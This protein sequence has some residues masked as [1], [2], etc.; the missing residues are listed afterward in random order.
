MAYN[1]LS[2]TIIGPDKIVAKQDGTFTQITGSISGSFID[3]NGNPVSFATIRA[4]SGSGDGTIGA[5]EDGTY[6]DGLFTDFHTGTLIGVPI[7]RFNELFKALVPPP[8]PNISRISSSQD[9][10]DAFLSFGASNDL[11]SDPTPYYT[12]ASGSGF[13][14]V[15]KGEIFETDTNGNH[16][17]LAIH[18]LDTNITGDINFH[19]AASVLG[20]STN[21]EANAF[22]NAETG[23]LKLYINSTSSAAHTLNLATASGSGN[24]GA[25]A[26]SSLNSSGSG[27]TNISTT[28][29]ATDANG[30]SFTMFNHRTAKF[31]VHSSSQRRGWNYAYVEHDIVGAQYVTNFIQWVN[32]D[33]AD[34][35][36]V[37]NNALANITLSGSRYIS[38]VQYNTSATADYQ[39]LINNFYKNVY[40]LATVT[41]TDST[42]N[43][44]ITNSTIP[45][46]GADDETKASAFTQSLSTS[47]QIILNE[48]I[49][50]TASV[51]HIFK[52]T[53]T[54][55]TSMSGFL[56]FT[57][58]V[59]A[60][61][62]T[63]EYFRDEATYRLTSASYDSQASVVTGSWNSET[64]MT[65]SGNH[66][67][68][69]QIYNQ[70][71]L[72]P[73]NT[74]NGGDFS[75]ISNTEAG[76]PDYSGVSG[77]RTFYRAFLNTGSDERDVSI[78]IKGSA[79][80]V[81]SSGSLGANN[82]IRVL[83][84]TPAKTD[85]MNLADN[86][87][88]NDV[89]EGAGANELGLDATVDGT[90]AVNVA[91]LGTKVVATNEYFLVK[92]EADAAWT[93]NIS[94][95][96]VVFGAGTGGI[97]YPSNL[98]VIDETTSNNGSNAKLSF[99]TSKP[100]TGYTSVGTSPNI[101]G[102]V[103]VNEL[104]S[105]NTGLSNERLGIYNRT[106][107]I[108]AKMNS[109]ISSSRIADGDAGNLQLFIN[110]TQ[111][112]SIDLSSFVSGS[113][114]NT[115]GSGFTGVTEVLYPT[116]ANGVRDY[117]E[118]YRTG[119][120][121]IDT[122]DQRNGWNYVLVKHTGTFGERDS[123]YIEWINDDDSSSIT[124]TGGVLN[125]FDNN[126]TYYYS[127]GIKHFASTPSA[128]FV[129]TSSNNYTNVYDDDSSDA[130]DFNDSLT[131][132]SIAAMTASGEGINSLTD[133]NG[134]SAYPTLL[135]SSGAQTGSVNYNLTLNFTPTTSLVGDFV[136]GGSVHTASIARAKFLQPPFN[137]NNNTY[138]TFTDSD[139]LTSSQSGFL[140]FSGS[141][142]NTNISSAEYFQGEGYRLENRNVTY[143]SQSDVV[144]SGNVW[145]SQNPVNDTSS[146]DNYADG[147]VVFGDKLIS[148][149]KA[150]A[151]GDCRNVSD[152][153]TLQ[154][155]TGN[156]NYT[157]AN[158]DVG[159]RTYV[160]YFRNSSGTTKTGFTVTFYGSGSLDDLSAAYT[161]GNFKFEF[162]VPH[163][164]SLNSTAW[165]DGGKALSFSGD[166][167]VDGNGGAQ[168][169]DSQF[170]LTIST[171][172]TALNVSLNG[173]NWLNNEYRLIRIRA[174]A[175]WDGYL[176]RIEVT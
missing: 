140:R 43:A 147:L 70:Q 47:D 3:Y 170:P 98:Q 88:F 57:P 8:A 128:S 37:T 150:G 162:K 113:D 165:Q 120:I 64:H 11:E 97:V 24:P 20:S 61:T 21:Y 135:T 96:S 85:W 36:T 14:A 137:A 154:A 51:T 72:S 157:L 81:S 68:G 121:L 87:V 1:I 42:S 55:S 103:D 74:T 118:P 49:G 149:T 71:L 110:G 95:I 156:V 130:I 58:T 141:E 133:A 48:S 143:L 105:V 116:F 89:S 7:D 25:G 16:F 26:S 54:G 152:G 4:G 86:F 66:S 123:T 73:L 78:T 159:T 114:L 29:S 27:F 117:T 35:V 108:S 174:S 60:A 50:A 171:G 80:I 67:D 124:V 109:A 125:N 136:A 158:L 59:S 148:P 176:D 138:S 146:Y 82:N 40:T 32:D 115:S 17:R 83:V 41:C 122:N 63:A 13:G 107:D 53:A 5:A 102:A 2:G 31:L 9:G 99:G 44:S 15:D 119:S 127:S 126:G 139:F 167:D 39:F 28:A 151:S 19:V 104:W 56:I 153:G 45:H 129:L 161:G 142:T 132:V 6:A 101:N 38:G 169:S 77:T 91:T 90:G 112:H 163:T 106:I 65:G 18:Q 33:N 75:S 94:E 164:N 155:P 92:I 52:G 131:N 173:G 111:R 76:N 23:S 100:I 84:K 144:V 172:G 30:N 62:D 175:S 34:T 145:D 22:G 10:D 46:I 134:V 166:K 93:G 12:V 160:R 168:G 79:N 69:L